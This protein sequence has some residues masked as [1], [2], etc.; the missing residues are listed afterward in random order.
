MIQSILFTITYLFILFLVMYTYKLS[1]KNQE[2][3]RC[4]ESIKNETLSIQKD[5][6]LIKEQQ[7]I[8]ETQDGKDGVL[9]EDQLQNNAIVT[10]IRE[11]GQ[12]GKEPNCV[13]WHQMRDAIKNLSPQF[14]N[15]LDTHNETLVLNEIRVCFLVRLNFRPYEIANVMGLSQQ[16][17]NNMYRKLNGQL[18]NE[19]TAKTFPE[20]IMN[21]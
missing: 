4:V 5:M 14:Y 7:N 2:M 18:F 12:C 16:R 19:N 1:R 15:V 20:N 6:N 9:C 8:D 10:K 13:E 17:I 3:V 11:Y 21:L